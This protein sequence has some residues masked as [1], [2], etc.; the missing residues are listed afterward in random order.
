MPYGFPSYTI[1]RRQLLPRMLIKPHDR[2]EPP[3][4]ILEGKGKHRPHLPFPRL[5]TR[6][7]W[8]S[9]LSEF[10]FRASPSACSAQDRPSP[11]PPV[12]I[13]AGVLEWEGPGMGASATGGSSVGVSWV[14]AVV[15]LAAGLLEP[16]T[17]PSAQV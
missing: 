15:G 13:R 9:G 3:L 1:P 2:G 14:G 7:F 12:S 10:Y 11:A 4:S 8:G 17:G 5:G 6:M 16:A